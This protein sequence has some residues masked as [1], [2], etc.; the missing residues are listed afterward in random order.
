VYKLQEVRLRNAQIFRVPFVVAI[1][2]V[3]LSSAI[4]CATGSANTAPTA[5]SVDTIVA[6]A[7][8]VYNGLFSASPG[9]VEGHDT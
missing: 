6:T 1:A 5:I 9:M 3:S 8:K 4:V 2:A 7:A